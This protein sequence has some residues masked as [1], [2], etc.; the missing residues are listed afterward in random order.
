MNILQH[1]FDKIKENN[2]ISKKKKKK[3]KGYNTIEG[4]EM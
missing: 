4:D 3:G 1:D 2:D